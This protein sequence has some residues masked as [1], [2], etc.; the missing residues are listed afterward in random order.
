MQRHP[1]DRL[2][3][4]PTVVT[5]DSGVRV[6]YDHVPSVDSCAIGIWVKAGTRDEPRGHAGVAHLVEHTAFRRTRTRTNHRIA[7]EFENVGAYANAYTTK[8]E[9]CYYVRT[10]SDH[11]LRVLPTLVD[12]VL[13]PQFSERDIN[14]ERSIIIEEIRSYE[15]EAEEYVFD[16]AEQQLFGSH[17]LGNP[18]LGT[19]ESVRTIDAQHVRD[20][21]AARYQ[22]NAIVVTVSG[23]IDF[24]RFL[25]AANTLIGFGKRRKNTVRRT[26]PKEIA[27]AKRRFA[28]NTQQAHIVMHRRTPGHA[29]K[30][31]SALTLLNLILGDGMSSRL[32]MRLR[33]SQGLAYNVSSQLQLFADVGML[34]VYAGADARKEQKVVQMIERELQ[35]LQSHSV[36]PSELRRAKEQARA[37]RL[38]SLESLSARMT[39]LGKGLLDDGKPEDPYAMIDELLSV[40]ADQMKA[41]TSEICSPNAWHQLAMVPSVE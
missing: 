2:T 24:P 14:K 34:S 36:K 38:M 5:L 11:A 8:E 26:M 35:Q 40:D 19:V 30:Q 15:D 18:I 27:I 17:A 12:V 7:R 37:S 1:T 4:S 31:R 16:L 6:A 21:H 41:L 32:N 28:G 10:L 33:E 39:L 13:N 20:F 9:T 23:N 22:A 29:A 25:D 3:F